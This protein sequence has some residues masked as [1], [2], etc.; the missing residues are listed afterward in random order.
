YWEGSWDRVRIGRYVIPVLYVDATT[1]RIWGYTTPGTAGTVT[2]LNSAGVVKSS[3]SVTASEPSGYFS[4]TSDVDV[5]AGDQVSA[6]IGALNRMAPVIVL[7]GALD[8]AGDAIY[9]TSLPNTQIGYRVYT[10]SGSYYYTYSGFVTTDAGGAFNL[11]IHNQADLAAGDY[12]YLYYID[13][14]DTHYQAVFYTTQPQVTVTNYPTAVP[15][16]GLVEVQ[17]DISDGVHPG[18]TAVR[19]DVE[20]HASDNAYGNA[21]P[22]RSGILGSVTATFGAP[23]GGT[24]Y[25]K[26]YASVDG[27]GVWSEEYTIDVVGEVRTMLVEPR[28]GT[29][30]DSTP[31]LAGVADPGWVI[32]VYDGATEIASAPVD[33]AGWFNLDVPTPLSAVRGSE[34]SVHELRVLARQGDEERPWSNLVRLT[35]DPSLIVNPAGVQV[36]TR[37]STQFLRDENGEANLG[38]RAWNRPGDIV[39]VSIP[40]SA[41]SVYS[42]SLVI[43]GAGTALLLDSG[44]HVFVGT[45]TAPA[46]GTYRLLLMVRQDGPAGPVSEIVLLNVVIAT[47]GYVYNAQLGPDYRLANAEIT[48]FELVDEAT[49]DW[50]VWPGSIWYQLNP[51]RTEADGYYGFFPLPGKYSLEVTIPGFRRMTSPLLTVADG[52]LYYNF[53]MMPLPRVYVPVVFRGY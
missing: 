23:M 50:Q 12:L 30:N 10:R 13:A 1:D 33:E 41:T 26:A 3:G 20:S 31:H 38:G 21:T 29:T 49:D 7:D 51:V 14:Q 39:E 24:I 25:F 4:F 40:I 19:W 44:D 53:A 22:W 2:V 34:A 43:E 37:G 36:V 27:Q 8:L 45:Y 28:S 47:D 42:A 15:P 32:T 16:A 18:S 46:S 9:G 35:V 48:V 52:P 11:N 6:Q 17:Y 5:V